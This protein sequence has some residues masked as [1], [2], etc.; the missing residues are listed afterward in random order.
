LEQLENSGL[1]SLKPG[2]ESILQQPHDLDGDAKF[3]A[4]LGMAHASGNLDQLANRERR[5]IGCLSFLRRCVRYQKY[6]ALAVVP[7]PIP[8]RRLFTRVYVH[9]QIDGEPPVEAAFDAWC[10]IILH[11]SSAILVAAQVRVPETGTRTS[12]RAPQYIRKT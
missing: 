1:G 3:L 4:S 5:R 9:V 10:E 11:Q 12:K 6:T 2:A 8:M 7:H